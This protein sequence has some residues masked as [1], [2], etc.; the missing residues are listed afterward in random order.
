MPVIL[1][2][3]GSVTALG[4]VFF[5]DLSG[6]AQA[7]IL[8]ASSLL[9]LVAFRAALEVHTREAPEYDEDGYVAME[10]KATPS[11]RPSAPRRSPLE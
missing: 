3:S 7:W 11:G 2:I 5:Q 8:L 1:L 9:G 4:F 10:E 6:R